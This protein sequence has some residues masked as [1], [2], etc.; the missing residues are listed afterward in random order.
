M[1]EKLTVTLTL[2]EMG[3]QNTWMGQ[4]AYFAMTHIKK[5][6]KTKKH[7]LATIKSKNPKKLFKYNTWFQYFT[8]K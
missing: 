2:Q 7:N 5:N 6:K 8:P 4:W 1:T 3:T